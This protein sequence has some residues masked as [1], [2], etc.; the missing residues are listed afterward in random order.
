M[1]VVIY[2]YT[3][4]YNFSWYFVYITKEILLPYVLCMKNFVCELCFPFSLV[5]R[6]F[7]HT[8][9]TYCSFHLQKVF[10]S[11]YLPKLNKI[12]GPYKDCY[13]EITPNLFLLFS[14]SKNWVS[15]RAYIYKPFFLFF[16]KCIN[17]YVYI[18]MYIY[19]LIYIYD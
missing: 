14:H 1:V 9:M 17:L 2:S 13:W 19:I 4:Y 8:A 15:K 11:S 3:Y 6:F 18:H 10:S 7:F 5:F 12:L 16:V